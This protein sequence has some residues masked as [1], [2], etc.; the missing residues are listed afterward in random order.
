VIVRRANVFDIVKIWSVRTAAIKSIDKKI[1]SNSEVNIWASTSMPENFDQIIQELQWYVAIEDDKIIGTG[2]LD[3][4]NQEIG[5]I[6]VEPNFQ[7]KGIGKEM[8][9][10]LEKIASDNGL[11]MLNLDATLN[12]TNFY[13]ANGYNII[14]KG[15]YHHVSGLKMDC[16]K[17]TKVL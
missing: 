14:S 17:M 4:K 15:K 3:I 1:Y 6:F 8:L 13:K 12:A 9:K 11:K 5:G 16:N 10:T 2:F 7:K